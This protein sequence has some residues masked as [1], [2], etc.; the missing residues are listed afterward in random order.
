MYGGLPAYRRSRY[1]NWQPHVRQTDF[2]AVLKALSKT[3][4]DIFALTFELLVSFM[5]T[6]KGV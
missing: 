5:G 3:Q 2:E 1:V 6:E 4:P